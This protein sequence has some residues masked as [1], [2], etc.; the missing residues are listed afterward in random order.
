MKKTVL[1]LLSVCCLVF[2]QE[3]P[4][5]AV[6]VSGSEDAAVNEA[7]SDLVLNALVKSDFYR[8]IDKSQEFI[9]RTIRAQDSV[10]ANDSLILEIG[11]SFDAQYLCFVK[12]LSVLGSNQVSARIVGIESDA[13]IELDVVRSPLG[14]VED[15]HKV[16][17]QITKPLT[18]RQ[19]KKSFEMAATKQAAAESEAIQKQ[20]EKEKEAKKESLFVDT[21]DKKEY[22]MKRI[23]GYYWFMRD[24]AYNSKEKYKWND[25]CEV[26]PEGWRL[27][28]NKEWNALK[29]TAS[30]DEL[31]E[32]A[33][34]SRGNW[35]SASENGRGFAWFWYFSRGK[36]KSSVG[37]DYVGKANAYGVR[38]VKE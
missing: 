10:L 24:I 2:A 34:K 31:K 20:A 23:G 12:I 26:C 16:S 6:Y 13:S 21:R 22:R 36:L 27:P 5:I 29:K 18:A 3:K 4:K 11:K 1:V 8:S 38:C 32:F 14:T 19:N 25:A 9:I 33:E 7:L 37:T 30:P 15:L 35:W 28:D 17:V